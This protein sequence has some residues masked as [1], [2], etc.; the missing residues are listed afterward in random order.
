MVIINDNDN[1]IDN[2]ISKQIHRNEARTFFNNKHRRRNN[3][4][5][6]HTG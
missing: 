2:N 3:K 4:M 1:D 6:E 5:Q